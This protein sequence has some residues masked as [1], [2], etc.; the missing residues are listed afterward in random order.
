MKEFD[1]AQSKNHSKLLTKESPKIDEIKAGNWEENRKPNNG[2]IGSLG[3]VFSNNLIIS[4]RSL[5]FKRGNPKVA[6]SLGER[7]LRIRRFTRSLSKN[8]LKNSLNYQA[9][10]AI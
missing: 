3:D 9:T 8:S 5:A 7:Q 4:L 10:Q 1:D 6:R 2:E